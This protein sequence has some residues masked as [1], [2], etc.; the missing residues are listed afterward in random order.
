MVD[1]NQTAEM[2]ERLGRGLLPQVESIHGKDRLATER[3]IST[4][5]FRG[6]GAV[7]PKIAVRF[8]SVNIA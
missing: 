7:G 2:H 6:W 1:G 3:D 8:F 5:D 4:F